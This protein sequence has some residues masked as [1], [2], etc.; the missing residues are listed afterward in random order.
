MKDCLGKVEFKGYITY[1]ELL[2]IS[3]TC[4]IGITINEPNEIIYQT[5][6]LASNKI[7]EYAV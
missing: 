4:H 5:F 3:S 6:G 1:D 7:Y 2:K